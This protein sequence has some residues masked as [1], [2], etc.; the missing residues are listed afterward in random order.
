[1]NM[2]SDLLVQ[3]LM[4]EARK[5]S[6]ISVL[7]IASVNTFAGFNLMIQTLAV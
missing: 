4:V 1:M 6:W 5:V 2:N 7:V 3:G